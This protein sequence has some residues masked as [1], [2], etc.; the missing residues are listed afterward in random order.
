MIYNNYKEIETTKDRDVERIEASVK[1]YNPEKGY[2]FL[3]FNDG[4][5]QE[6]MIHSSKLDAIKCAYIKLGDRVICDVSL[7]KSG[8][9]VV[10]VIEVKFSSSE[11]RTLSGFI[12]SRL[13]SFDPENLEEVEG[14][15]KWYNPGK[16]YGFITPQNKGREI[17]LHQSV[18][19]AAEYHYL[20]PG[21]PVKA[22]IIASE[23]GLEARRL[24]VL[25][26]DINR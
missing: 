19:K 9:Q 6:I 18:L 11:K 15:I 7:G 21:T 24:T 23:R 26:N 5:P 4:S 20:E 3:F 1:W 16:G 13:S 22:K 8:F 14:V 2:G 25:D 12:A 10:R 17:F